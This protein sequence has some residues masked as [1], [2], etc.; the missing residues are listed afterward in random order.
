MDDFSTNRH[1]EIQQ[2]QSTAGAPT[3]H[4]DLSFPDGTIAILTGSVYFLV[5]KGLLCRHS[6]PFQ[7]ATKALDQ[8]RSKQLEGRPVLHVTDSPHDMCHFLSALYDGILGVKLDPP[9]F[10]VVDALLRL[11]TKYQVKHIRSS[12]LREIQRTW[13]VRLAQW[14]VREAEATDSSG[15]YDA[16]QYYPHPILVINLA[17]VIQAPEL[18]PS[19]FY[20]LSRGVVSETTAGYTDSE[21]TLHQLSQEDL[22]NVLKGREH[23]SRFLSTFIVNELEG[24]APSVNCVH[25]GDEDTGHRRACQAAFESITFEILRDVNGITHRS[26]DPLFAIVDAELMQTR[27]DAHSILRACEFCRLEF[28]AAV[29]QARAEFWGKMPCWFGVDLEAGVWA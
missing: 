16:R 9:N 7:Q 13:P 15:Q 14:E 18:L 8:T 1:H 24:R 19:A 5:H 20:D 10:P 27:D 11:T 26:S 4:P 29:D 3:R 22:M 23:A 25:G 2:P 6:V 21:S 12:L 17:R 28:G